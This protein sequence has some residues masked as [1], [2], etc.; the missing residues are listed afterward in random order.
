MK[1]KVLDWSGNS[2]DLK[3]IGIYGQSSSSFSS[4]D[5]TTKTKLIEAIIR[6]WFRNPEIKKNVPQVSGFDAKSSATSPEKSWWSYHVLKLV[7][8][9]K[10]C[11]CMKISENVLV[12]GHYAIN[13]HKGVRN[14]FC[15]ILFSR[16]STE[17]LRGR[18]QLRVQERHCPITLHREAPLMYYITQK[19]ALH[20]HCCVQGRIQG[21]EVR[22]ITP[23][24]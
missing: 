11:S 9:V 21:W 8:C 2:S 13:L 15:L 19:A 23:F 3:L 20:W 5:C 18:G 10:N 7:Y 12:F 1:I 6:I 16:F 14:H 22:A 17:G 4:E 24:P